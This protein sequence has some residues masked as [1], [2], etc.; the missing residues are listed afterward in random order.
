MFLYGTLILSQKKT[1]CK[2]SRI[3]KTVGGAGTGTVIT[4]Q[5]QGLL[6]LHPS[7]LAS[8]SFQTC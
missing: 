3:L 4:H 1:F 2:P 5:N 6:L 7:L 8:F